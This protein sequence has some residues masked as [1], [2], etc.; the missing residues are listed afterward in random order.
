MSSVSQ[1]TPPWRPGVAVS[2]LREAL[3]LMQI[4]G[5]TVVTMIESADAVTEAAASA[6]AAAVPVSDPLAGQ[7]IDLLA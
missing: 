3:N 1:A 4:Q 2:V 5:E 6:Q 7:S